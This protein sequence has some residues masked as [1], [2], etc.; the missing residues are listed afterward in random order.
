[1]TKTERRDCERYDFELPVQAT[2]K[3]A[4]GNIKKET[5]ITKD[6]SSS[7]AFMMCKNLIDKDCEIDFQIDLPVFVENAKSR[8]MASGKIVRNAGMT[9]SE[10]CYGHGIV[11]ENYSFTRV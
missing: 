6:V 8:I 1:M 11:F 2:W 4:D 5:G 7:G 3:D 9:H 10:K